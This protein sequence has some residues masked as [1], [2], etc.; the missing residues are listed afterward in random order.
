MVGAKT[1]IIWGKI[2]AKLGHRAWLE[3]GW[4]MVRAQGMLGVGLRVGV[5]LGPDRSMALLIVVRII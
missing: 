4:G 5:W 1:R 3:Y 2:G